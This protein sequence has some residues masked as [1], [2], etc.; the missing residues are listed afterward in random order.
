MGLSPTVINGKNRVLSQIWQSLEIPTNNRRVPVDDTYV[1][2]VRVPVVFSNEDLSSDVVVSTARAGQVH[3]AAKRQ[4]DIT[5][6]FLVRR[7]IRH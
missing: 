4:S 5:C 1:F 6:I 7:K 3:S 2:I